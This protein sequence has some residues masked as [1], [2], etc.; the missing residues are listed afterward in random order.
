MDILIH[1]SRPRLK[2]LEGYLA[3]KLPKA[4]L[5]VDYYGE[6]NIEAYRGS[7]RVMYHNGVLPKRG[8]TWHLED[9]VLPDRRIM[10]WMR[11]LE[12]REGII[13]GFGTTEKFGEVKPEDMWY[14]FPCIRIPNDYLRDFEHWI[15]TSGDEDVAERMKLGKGIDFLFRKYVIQNPIP[16]YHTNP[17]MVEHIDD[18]IG[19]S[20]INERDKP[21]KAIRFEDHEGIEE[22]KSW[23]EGNK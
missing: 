23:L 18:L 3:K 1:A 15:E 13:C 20:L 9:D 2:Y 7:Y 10:K 8:N 22:L 4:H 6:G 17:C 5:M 14:S 21:I 12:S 16:I 19:G 11:E